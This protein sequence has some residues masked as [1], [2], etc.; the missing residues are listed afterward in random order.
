[1]GQ[2][3]GPEEACILT[4]NLSLVGSLG[5]L[6]LRPGVLDGHFYRNPVFGL[7]HVFTLGWVSLLILGVLLR[8]SPALLGAEPRG[9]GLGFT[10]WGLWVVGASGLVAHMIRANGSGCGPRSA[11]SRRRSS[12]P[13][14]IWDPPSR[15]GRPSVARY[16]SL[17]MPI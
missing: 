9:K 12:C 2:S 13:C 17:A 10:V 15:P 1:V 4:A 3:R 11:C 16:A 5:W 8:L 7:T 6:A 14:S